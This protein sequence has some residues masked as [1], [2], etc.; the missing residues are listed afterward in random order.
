M[1]HAYTHTRRE[2]I[3]ATGVC[4]NLFLTYLWE[5]ALTNLW[6]FHY[7][8][9][10]CQNRDLIVGKNF[11][12]TDSRQE[13][14]FHKVYYAGGVEIALNAEQRVAGVETLLWVLKQMSW[15]IDFCRLIGSE[16][17][18]TQNSIFFTLHITRSETAANPERYLNRC[19]LDKPQQWQFVD[20][21]GLLGILVP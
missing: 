13:Y 9:I 11:I 3:L 21:S 7:S 18:H 2:C 1:I 5:P 14:T 19:Y 8:R 4:R 12:L 16:H 17:T 6:E 20:F 15:L 10:I